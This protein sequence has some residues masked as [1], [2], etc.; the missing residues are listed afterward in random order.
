M[1]KIEEKSKEEI[2]A[3]ELIEQ[4]KPYVY[5]FMGSDMLI[6]RESDSV[7]LKNACICAMVCVDEIIKD[8]RG[9][10]TKPYLTVTQ[11]I[12]VTKFWQ[13]VK[14]ILIDKEKK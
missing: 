5:C 1:S 12:E 8:F 10:R 14:Q 2:K 3:D 13:K 7:V 9:F 4:F 11:A 6:N